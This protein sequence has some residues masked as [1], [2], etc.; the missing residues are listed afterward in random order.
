MSQKLPADGFNRKKM[1][2][3]NKK[4]VKNYDE[5]S[6]IECILEVDVEYP[7]SNLQNNLRFLPK[8]IK[9]KKC[10]KLVCNLYDKNNCTAQIRTLKQA[11]DHE[12]ILKQVHKLI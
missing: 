3:F 12:L 10:Y 1:S 2:K 5:N 11:L 7:K 6:N 4:F 9:M 8:K